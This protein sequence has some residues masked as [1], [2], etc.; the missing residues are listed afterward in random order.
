M[1]GAPRR[2]RP[3]PRQGRLVNLAPPRH[4]RPTAAAPPGAGG[5]GRPVARDSTAGA[6]CTAGVT[7]PP[8][9][10]QAQEP[11]LLYRRIGFPINL[12]G[13]GGP[14]CT[15]CHALRGRGSRPARPAPRRASAPSPPGRR[16]A[17]RT[18]RTGPGAVGAA[19]YRHRSWGPGPEPGWC[20]ESVGE[21]RAL[22]D[23]AGRG[24][25]GADEVRHVSTGDLAAAGRREVGP[26]PVLALPRIVDQPGRADQR[27][28]QVAVLDH[29]LHAAHVRRRSRRRFSAGSA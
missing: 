17:D 6:P 23:V 27:P 29:P 4:G 26:D 18:P 14:C 11:G 15:E 7:R 9:V 10:M 1:A 16:S 19:G 25:R 5:E 2:G 28:V 3:G 24:K 21:G 12:I 20:R 8:N 13:I 22:A